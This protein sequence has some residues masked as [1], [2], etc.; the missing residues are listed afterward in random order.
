MA[1]L[2]SGINPRVLKEIWQDYLKNSN[3]KEKEEKLRQFLGELKGYQISD[4]TQFCPDS[5]L[6]SISN[7]LGRELLK[8]VSHQCEILEDD[9]AFVHFLQK[10]TGLY[11]L[12]ALNILAEQ[13]GNCNTEVSNV[14]V[15]VL[16]CLLSSLFELKDD[17][18]LALLQKFTTLYK[19][20]LSGKKVLP[21]LYETIHSKQPAEDDLD[22]LSLIA[23]LLDI[24]CKLSAKG[25]SLTV[26]ESTVNVSVKLLAFL[27]LLMKEN[28]SSEKSDDDLPECT[29][30][31]GVKL[32]CACM[33]M[34]SL[35]S[36][37]AAK[38]TSDL[39]AHRIDRSEQIEKLIQILEDSKN[40]LWCSSDFKEQ[41]P[42]STKVFLVYQLFTTYSLLGFL[43]VLL[44]NGVR[45]ETASCSGID[46]TRKVHY[47]DYLKTFMK[48]NASGFIVFVIASLNKIVSIGNFDSKFEELL[49]MQA[50]VVLKTTGQLVSSLKRAMMGAGKSDSEK[51]TFWFDEPAAPKTQSQQPRIFSHVT[52]TSSFHRTTESSSDEDWEQQQGFGN[53]Q[54]HYYSGRDCATSRLCSAILTAYKESAVEDIDV[55]CLT[56]LARC[57]ICPCMDVSSTIVTL[58]SRLVKRSPNVQ[59]LA[60]RLFGKTLLQQN[61]Q[62]MNNNNRKQ[63]DSSRESTSADE[64]F[65]AKTTYPPIDHWPCFEHLSHIVITNKDELTVRI[66]K[67][68][69]ALSKL[70]APNLKEALFVKVFVP[71][72]LTYKDVKKTNILGKICRKMTV[73]VANPYDSGYGTPSEGGEKTEKSES[74]V[75]Q[76]SGFDDEAL[77]VCLTAIYLLLDKEVLQARFMK[78]GGVKCI[79]NFLGDEP[80]HLICLGILRLLATPWGDSL[81]ETKETEGPAQIADSKQ[82]GKAEVVEILLHSM[83]LLDARQENPQV[84]S[85]VSEFAQKIRISLRLPK[86]SQLLCQLWRTG[87]RVLRKNALFRESFLKSGGHAYVVTV[88]QVIKECL[89]KA[90]SRSDVHL[91]DQ[92]VS[93]VMLMEC[94]MAVGLEFGEEQVDGVQ[95]SLQIDETVRIIQR[96]IQKD[97]FLNEIAGKTFCQTLLNLAIGAVSEDD[98]LKADLRDSEK[99]LFDFGNTDDSDSESEVSQSGNTKVVGH[100]MLGAKDVEPGYEG[101]AELETGQ[102]DISGRGSGMYMTRP[103]KPRDRPKRQTHTA[104]R[105]ILYPSMFEQLIYFIEHDGKITVKDRPLVLQGLEGMISLASY[106]SRNRHILCKKGLLSL[107]FRRFNSCLTST[108]ASI[109]AVQ[110]S[111][112][113]LI[114]V[115]AGYEFH[116]EELKMFLQFLQNETPAW[117]LLLRAL[118]NITKLS[119][120]SRGPLYTH[121]FP[122]NASVTEASPVLA[123]N[124][125]G[126]QHGNV[127]FNSPKFNKTKLKR[128]GDGKTS[129][130]NTYPET[131]PLPWDSSAFELKVSQGLS[132]PVGSFSLAFWL[133]VDSGRQHVER[134]YHTRLTRDKHHWKSR[135]YVKGM[136][137]DDADNVAHVMTFGTRTAWFEVW[138]NFSKGTLICRWFYDDSVTEA[139]IAREIA[140]L[141]FPVKLHNWT[142]I[143][144]S[145]QAGPESDVT[146]GKVTL[147]VDGSCETVKSYRYPGIPVKK[148]DTVSVL[149]GQR[150]LD[151]CDETTALRENIHLQAYFKLG[152]VAT[153]IGELNRDEGPLTALMS[154]LNASSKNQDK[155]RTLELDEA[156]FLKLLGANCQAL[157]FHFTENTSQEYSNHIDLKSL[158]RLAECNVQSFF[159]GPHGEPVLV[160]E[161][162]WNDIKNSLKKQLLLVYSPVH[163]EKFLEYK[164]EGTNWT[165]NTAYSDCVMT[166]DV[167]RNVPTPVIHRKRLA[168][169]IH[170]IGGIVVFLFLFAKT[171]EKTDDQRAQADA[172]SVIF[173]LAKENVTYAKELDGLLANKMILK[174]LLSPNCIPGYHFA[175]VL[176]YAACE[177]EVFR[178]TGLDD[179]PYLVNFNTDAVVSNF[180]ILRDFL[181]NWRIWFNSG[182]SSSWEMILHALEA[183]TSSNHRW[184][185]FNI[186]QFERADALGALLLGCQEIQG[187]DLS[188]SWTITSLHLKI[189]QNLLGCSA[190][191][192]VLKRICEFLV[193]VHPTYETLVIQAPGNLYFAPIAKLEDPDE[194][195]QNGENEDQQE[196][197][198]GRSKAHTLL[199]EQATETSSIFS[200]SDKRTNVLETDDTKDMIIT[201]GHLPTTSEENTRL[202]FPLQSAPEMNAPENTSSPTIDKTDNS[203][204]QPTSRPD[205]QSEP[206][207]INPREARKNVAGDSYDVVSSSEYSASKSRSSQAANSGE[208]YVVVENRPGFASTMTTYRHFKKQRS[209]LQEH[210]KLDDLRTGLLELINSALLN[211][212]DIAV[213]SVVGEILKF[214][215]FLCFV[216]YPL[217][218]VRTLSVEILRKIL[219]RGSPQIL[220]SFHQM[221]GFHLLA[222]QIH[223]HPITQ[224]LA[225]ACFQLFF[226][227]PVSINQPSFLDSIKR[228]GDLAR[229]VN[230]LS[231]IPLLGMLEGAVA[232]PRVFQFLTQSLVKMLD[233]VEDFLLKAADHGLLKTFVNAVR[234]LCVWNM[235]NSASDKTTF[236]ANS[237]VVLD[238]LQ[239]LVMAIVYRALRMCGDRYF[240]IFDDLLLAL[241]TLQYCGADNKGFRLLLVQ[242]SRFLQHCALK[243]SLEYLEYNQKAT[244]INRRSLKKAL[245]LTFKATSGNED[246]CFLGD[247]GR[248]P[249]W[250]TLD[251]S[252]FPVL[253]QTSKYI[254]LPVDATPSEI[255]SRFHDVLMKTVSLICYSD[256]WPIVEAP[257]DFT[258]NY[259]CFA[260]PSPFEKYKQA[261]SCFLVN[262]NEIFTQWIFCLL[263]EFH[264]FSLNVGA[265]DCKNK[266]QELLLY[267]KDRI[268][269][270]LCRL[271]IYLMAPSQETK[272]KFFALQLTKMNRC[273]SLFRN[274]LSGITTKQKDRTMAYIHAFLREPDDEFSSEEK[275]LR[276]VVEEFLKNVEEQKRDN[277]ESEAFLQKEEEWKKQ[278]HSNKIQWENKKE[279]ERKRGDQEF[280]QLCARIMSDAMVVTKVSVDV[281]DK[282]RQNLLKH[283]KTALS[284]DVQ[285]HKL[286]QM[287]IVQVTHER[288]IW[289][290]K[291][292]FPKSWQLDRT[293]GPCRVRCR[294]QRCHLGIDEKFIMPEHRKS[295]TKVVPLSYLFDEPVSESA[296]KNVYH[297][298]NTTDTIC[299]LYRCKSIMPSRKVPGEILIGE[300][301]VYFVGEES[302][303]DVNTAQFFLDDEDITSISWLFQEI[304]EIL[305][306]RYA[307]K[308]NALEIFLTNGR[309]FLL[310]FETT[311]DRET[312]YKELLA[313]DLPNLV[314]TTENVADLTQRW[315]TGELTNFAYLTELNKQ[316]CRSFNDLMQYPVFPLVL[317]DYKCDVL[318]LTDVAVYRDLSKPIAV[319]NPSRVPKYQETYK[320]LQEQYDITKKLDPM[321]CIPPYHYGSH[322]SNSGTVLH[323][324]V[325]L[326]PFTKM[327]LAYQD[328]QFDVPDRTFH[329]IE[330]T[331]NLS[332]FASAPDVK[333]LIPEFFF[334][335]E[336]LLNLEGFDFGLRQN[337][338]RVMDVRLPSWSCKDPRLF[339]LIHRQALE[340][341]VVSYRINKWIDL[342]FGFKQ[343][344]Q[345]AIEAV[346]VFHPS[347][348]VGGIDENRL[349]DPVQRKA[350]QTMIETYGQTP[351]RLFTEQHPDKKR[352]GLDQYTTWSGTF[353][354]EGEGQGYSQ[355][356]FVERTTRGQMQDIPSPVTTVYGIKWGQYIGSPAYDK[357]VVCWLD[358]FP[359]PVSRLV[360][361]PHSNLFVLPPNSTHVIVTRTRNRTMHIL[362]SAVL[363]WNHVDDIIRIWD[364]KKGTMSSF[365]ENMNFHKITSCAVSGQC[366]SLWLGSSTGCLHV[367]PTRYD[368]NNECGLEI[369]GR[370]I[371]LQG[372]EAS[373]TCIEISEAFSIVV[374]GSEDGTAIIWDLNRLCYIR[375]LEDHSSSVSVVA[376]SPTSGDIVTV[377]HTGNN[378]ASEL[379]LWSV[380]GRLINKIVCQ[381]TIKC[382]AFSRV[383]EG[384]SVNAVAAGLVNGVV[385][386][387][388]TW[389]LEHMTDIKDETCQLPIVSLAYSHTSL[390]LFTVNSRGIVRAWGRS[391]RAYKPRIL[392]GLIY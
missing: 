112:L 149:V 233:V 252:A 213:D 238:N 231:G 335:P 191:P 52:S 206:I 308:D 44:D 387:W 360:S 305:R 182:S 320:S 257:W 22:L 224:E 189:I 264:D 255:A 266:W 29:W 359:T 262:S 176:F 105:Y 277:S 89:Y 92:V 110:K 54:C 108:D 306:R 304:R 313:K 289:H 76:E 342:V 362:W 317:A 365:K 116:C 205:G 41:H 21:D 62:K 27:H 322:Y 50:T 57:G 66:L 269:L 14:L 346:N 83:L 282:Q 84:D 381:E 33:S 31:P 276:T 101:D 386:L 118:N 187:E 273:D 88:L 296:S 331:W 130:Q 117:G 141:K 91:K 309:T 312:V 337:G 147:L 278:D 378:N 67:Y 283:V 323:F 145:V 251:P 310:A 270:Q 127:K 72:V 280:N 207:A 73:N 143:V 100:R 153:F 291:E 40:S 114:V 272:F 173:T 180:E 19:N 311:R 379:R 87:F 245:R 81:D 327:F 210:A 35:Q 68:L 268:R 129:L 376:V 16:P 10:G 351:A 69:K 307:L 94:A 106:S 43:L 122:A 95:L 198:D 370:K 190:N 113:D 326:V 172:L 350:V 203:E 168:E 271:F 125:Q 212:A 300:K 303:A 47:K 93:C 371:R 201:V 316:A 7:L 286:W 28:N 2:E 156:A 134:E 321:N 235:N 237:G 96:L 349:H 102:S 98:S 236:Q 137:N 215:N 55:V 99:L 63:L 142:H 391:E 169:A 186:R 301:R 373:I 256:P 159:A 51:M 13:I 11:L 193:A 227:Q 344:G 128:R 80:S 132:W 209:E 244:K 363:S 361:S 324:L 318:D 104:D 197:E 384:V 333:E 315:Q 9:A 339:T 367:W 358:S 162:R 32:V 200:S 148:N 234:A 220:A 385:R 279:I 179:K 160:D 103:K 382:V 389:T 260:L 247:I 343:E 167:I 158:E 42:C 155:R 37:F 126:S 275:E 259:S 352:S 195:F 246:V 61:S 48:N 340:S 369:L 144:V 111:I 336:F 77:K 226:Q 314:T 59:S 58:L 181:L 265:Q 383:P 74:K 25:R 202:D 217:A 199:S 348:Y 97:K 131:F 285:S 355:K 109:R 49:K 185:Q 171:V 133:Y 20:L 249:C 250:G 214:E 357:P 281:Q 330:T 135:S 353:V 38:N 192:Q 163:P 5:E 46:S 239:Y 60:L 78:L 26:A 388:N 254:Q 284:N 225:E 332:S 56:S 79:V 157:D 12:Q 211:L 374:T 299:F 24:I 243:F 253:W 1:S 366:K 287:L 229:R 86:V 241:D 184:S 123:D 240:Q 164:L 274:M 177:G 341:D 222:V 375:S 174:V 146:G 223:L 356:P 136:A 219:E 328:K 150:S 390:H 17:D 295:Q 23:L 70:A 368:R 107:I 65:L 194:M 188:F 228:G 4:E 3:E 30:S 263:L 218:R 338:E 18:A 392:S 15:S 380:N 151:K 34:C 85:T 248:E 216:N 294:L 242:C 170:G 119:V 258:L 261:D 45:G 152:N 36:F 364:I 175:K 319:Q 166:G 334:L 178:E 183:L 377:S 75:V 71:F 329:A 293:E 165:G 221:S 292:F 6:S 196:I 345:A 204:D 115:L 120:A 298:F 121:R 372:H 267:S 138:V 154:M 8:V 297:I 90:K 232:C 124:G 354:G 208:D 64:V 161:Q 288:A 140:P 347:T 53:P 290:D 325:R 302:D 39:F 82:A 230:I 139:S